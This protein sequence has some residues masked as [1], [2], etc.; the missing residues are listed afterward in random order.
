MVFVVITV[1]F[2]GWT[3]TS[4][5]ECRASFRTL[6]HIESTHRAFRKSIPIFRPMPWPSTRL[7]HL[8]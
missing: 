4:P 8:T 3:T 2:R 7:Q 1:T 5:R 6:Q